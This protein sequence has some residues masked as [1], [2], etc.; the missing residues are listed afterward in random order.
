ME[1]VSGIQAVQSPDGSDK[2]LNGQ[3]IISFLIPENMQ[4]ADLAIL[5]WD[6]SQWMDLKS[7]SFTDG[8]AVI[9]GGYVTGDS[10]F[11]AITNFSGNF[12]LVAK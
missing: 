10:Y 12:V 5:Y 6:G 11:E 3:V 9:N 4:S 1:Y 8:R 2:A 7:A